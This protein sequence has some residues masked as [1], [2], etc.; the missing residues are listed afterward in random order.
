MKTYKITTYQSLIGKKE[1]V[2]LV[3]ETYGQWIIYDHKKPTYHVDCFNFDYESNQILNHLLLNQQ[4]SI[5]EVV[6]RINK[7]KNTKLSI[8][9]PMFYEIETSYKLKEL[10]LE[11]LPLEWVN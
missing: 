6:K 10:D 3:G 9:K 2:E 11:P 5:E 1:I 4:K 7:E 8:K